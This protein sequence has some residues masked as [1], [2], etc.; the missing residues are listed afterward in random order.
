MDK[1][2]ANNQKKALNKIMSTLLGNERLPMLIVD[3]NPRLHEKS[4]M[5][6]RAVAIFGFSIFGKEHN[7]LLNKNFEIDY[8]I[9]IVF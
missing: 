4:V 9:L 6:A 7:Y 3:Q 2:N 5:N 1:E 8:K